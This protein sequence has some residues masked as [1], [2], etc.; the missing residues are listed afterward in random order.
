MEPEAKEKIK[1]LILEAERRAEL[2]REE[3]DRATRA[4][5]DV[6]AQR[7]ELVKL[8]AQ[9]RQMKAVYVEGK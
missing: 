5:I 1:E 3:I 9:I 2:A 4:G 6:E 7:V 8:E